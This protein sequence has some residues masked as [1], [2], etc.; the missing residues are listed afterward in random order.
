[1]PKFPT[2]YSIIELKE[3]IPNS[4]CKKK[5]EKKNEKEKQFKCL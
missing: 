2:L 5:K 4:T 1:M 3:R